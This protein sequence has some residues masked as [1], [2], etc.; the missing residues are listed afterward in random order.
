MIGWLIRQRGRRNLYGERGGY[1]M[2]I[3]RVWLVRLNVK[4][5]VKVNGKDPGWRR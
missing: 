3:S 4:V 1:V 2:L 5:K